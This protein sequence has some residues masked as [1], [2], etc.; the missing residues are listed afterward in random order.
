MADMKKD[1]LELR[2]RGVS[3]EDDEPIVI[4]E[5][6][7]MGSRLQVRVGPFE[8]SAIII[9]LEGIAVPRPLT[10]DLLAQVF[11]EGGFSLDEVEL[12]G[13][14]QDDSR[15]RLSYRKGLRKYE[16]EVRPSDA[17]ALALRLRAPIFAEPSLLAKKDE[18][19]ARWARP[20]ILPFEDM[21]GRALRA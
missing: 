8:A 6:R 13:E 21:K 10:H 18:A 11:E 14:S 5:D 20:N 4:L 1:S 12:F 9:E 19:E 16:K 17:L 7:S 15:A 3:M 2:I